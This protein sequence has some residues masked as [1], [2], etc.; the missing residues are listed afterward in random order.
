MGEPWGQASRPTLRRFPS[1]VGSL[2]FKDRFSFLQKS[3]LTFQVILTIINQT[4]Q[5]LDALEEELEKTGQELSKSELAKDLAEALK[6]LRRR[7]VVRVVICSGKVYY[8]LLE[9]RRARGLDDV[10]LLRIEQLY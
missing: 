5:A 1:L 8:D 2:T 3:L 7:H 4:A 9:G 10:A 6:L